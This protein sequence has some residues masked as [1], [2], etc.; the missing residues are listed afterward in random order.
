MGVHGSYFLFAKEKEGFGAKLSQ[1]Q[2]TKKKWIIVLFYF[3][4]PKSLIN[5]PFMKWLL[6]GT[7]TTWMHFMSGLGKKQGFM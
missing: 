7:S 1:K 5:L 2:W 4:A 3:L 6:P